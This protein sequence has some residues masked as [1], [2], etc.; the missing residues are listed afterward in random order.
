MPF[1]LYFIPGGGSSTLFSYFIKGSGRRQVSLPTKNVC[2]PELEKM[3][4]KF[5]LNFAYL[6]TWKHV[7][8]CSRNCSPA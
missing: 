6:K 3:I 4:L 7:F 5:P 1:K 2:A 8:D